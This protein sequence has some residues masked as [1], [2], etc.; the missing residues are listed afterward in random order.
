MFE[1]ND[2][3][4]FREHDSGQIPGFKDLDELA[5]RATKFYNGLVARKVLPA[6]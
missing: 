4:F 3:T 5:K 2:L 1:A 6:E